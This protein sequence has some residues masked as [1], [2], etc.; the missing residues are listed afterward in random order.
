M[1]TLLLPYAVHE[2]N[3]N[4]LWWISLLKDLLAELAGSDV[5]SSELHGHGDV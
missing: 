1:R 2:Q 4:D 5:A 3:K